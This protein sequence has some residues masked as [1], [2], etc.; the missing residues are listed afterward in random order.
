M[1][2]KLSPE[3]M[4]KLDDRKEAFDAGH[5][6]GQRVLIVTM[7]GAWLEQLPEH[8]PDWDAQRAYEILGGSR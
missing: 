5:R 2:E 4:D 1:A 8:E 7:L 6:A 3:L